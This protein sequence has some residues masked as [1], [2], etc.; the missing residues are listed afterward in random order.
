[1]TGDVGKHVVN[2]LFSQIQWVFLD[3]G[4]TLIDETIAMQATVRGNSGVR[5][6]LHNW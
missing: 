1:M 5:D 4:E 2:S 3:L 6:K